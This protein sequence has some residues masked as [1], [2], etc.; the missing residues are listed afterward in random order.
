MVGHMKEE[1]MVGH[2]GDDTGAG[3]ALGGTVA[4]GGDLKFPA[5]G[6]DGTSANPVFAYLQSDETNIC[7]Q[8]ILH[9][10]M[11]ANVRSATG[12]RYDDCEHKRG[13]FWPVV[14]A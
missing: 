5:V 1:T 4:K 3:F 9:T 2:E 7:A 13:K 11:Q 8:T 12:K 10:C 6:A 14:G